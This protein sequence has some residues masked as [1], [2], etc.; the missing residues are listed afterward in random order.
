MNASTLKSVVV[1]DSFIEHRYTK[2][3][4]NFEGT[5]IMTGHKVDINATNEGNFCESCLVDQKERLKNWSD[6]VGSSK[7]HSYQVLGVTNSSDF[8]E[9]YGG[10]CRNNRHLCW[11][12]VKRSFQ[13]KRNESRYLIVGSIILPNSRE[14][15]G[16][17]VKQVN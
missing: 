14:T 16:R 13:I 5:W 2:F 4:E 10:R 9:W 8:Y 3:K 11:G 17:Y 12:N 1:S 7:I 6:A 15:L